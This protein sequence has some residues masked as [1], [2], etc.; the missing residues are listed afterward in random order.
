MS[1]DNNIILAKGDRY[2]DDIRAFL[3]ALRMGWRWVEGSLCHTEAWEMEDRLSGDS[4]TK[5]TAKVLVAMMNEVFDFMNFTTE[6]GEDFPEGKLPSLDIN[7]WVENGRILY[8]FFEKPMATNLMV[9]AGSALSR[10]VKMSTLAEEVSRRLRNT[11]QR[12]DCTRRM[13]SLE[14]ACTK[15][16]T[17]GHSDEFIRQAVEKGINAFKDKVERSNLDKTHPGYQPMFPKAG[18]RRELRDREKALKTSTWYKG[19]DM[20]EAWEGVQDQK[21]MGGLSRER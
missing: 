12:L 1:R 5:R 20:K 11:S 7:I 14:R 2:V 21:L 9:E 17:S 4:A 13:E 16:K 15:M 3:K 19:K 6:I 10:E 18:W 8:E